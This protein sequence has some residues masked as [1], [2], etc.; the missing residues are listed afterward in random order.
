[1]SLPRSVPQVL[2]G[3][4]RTPVVAS[5]CPVCGRVELQGRQTA[6]SAAC[7][8]E[9]SCRRE[10]ERRQVRDREIRVLLEMVLQ[11]LE[12]EAVRDT[13]LVDSPPHV[14]RWHGGNAPRHAARR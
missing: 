13:R 4:V 9:R 10:A 7:R 12:E 3:S 11:K 14:P 6:C 2:A 8:R 1:M 5:R